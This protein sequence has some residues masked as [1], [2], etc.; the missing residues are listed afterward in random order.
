MSVET[1]TDNFEAG[2]GLRL[3]W[4]GTLAGPVLWFSNQQINLLLSYWACAH[5]SVIV[6]HAV[7][8]ACAL[9]ALL[10]GRMSLRHWRRL[11]EHQGGDQDP[12]RERSAFMA[13]V[14][15][16]TSFLFALVILAHAIPVILLDPC[17]R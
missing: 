11:R 2:R 17:R 4:I 3:L 10:A 15:V 14:G 8:V 6:L 9:G 12:T 1:H 16:L 5:G 13:L 7:T